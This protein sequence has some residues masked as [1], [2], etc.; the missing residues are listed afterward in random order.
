M[1]TTPVNSAYLVKK[2]SFEKGAGCKVAARLG[3]RH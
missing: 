2:V 1:A 3:K